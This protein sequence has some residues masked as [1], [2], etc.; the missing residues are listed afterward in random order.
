MLSDY[1]IY[2]KTVMKKL[3]RISS[4]K[5][6]F[7]LFFIFLFSCR[8]DLQSI[9]QPENYIDGNFSQVFDAFWNGM[10]NNY[11]FWDIDTTNWD[12][13]Y[14][15][16]KP[17]FE[18]LN[19]NDSNDVR[20]SVNYF[21]QMTQG[22]VDSHFN[23][24]FGYNAIQDSTVDPAYERKQRSSAFHPWNFY[25]PLDAARY[26]DKGYISG[27]DSTT[28]AGDLRFA[29]AGTIS[30]KILFFT[31]NEFELK[32]SYASSKANGLQPVLKYFFNYV[33]D[34]P[35]NIKGII[36]DLRGNGGGAVEDLN[37]LMGRMIDKPLHI[38]YTRYK[39]GNGR[40]DYTPW[41]DAVITPQSGAA[42]LTI[43]IIVLADNYSVSL[44]ELTTMAV[45][46]LPTGRFVGETTWGATGP[47]APNE[48]FNGGQ[49]TAANFLFAYTSSSMFKYIDGNIYE[50]KGF[51]PDVSVPYNAAALRAGVDLQLEKAISLIP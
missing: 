32:S 6:I 39:S 35:A 21:R 19:L 33:Q 1:S 2:T 50:G 10:N 7:S 45:H 4:G 20:K 49:F 9:N 41:A 42:A 11:I 48:F 34:P 44:A 17:V 22:L 16:Y 29:L 36:L 18:K 12:N 28:N 27:Y 47:L 5:I 3:F 37:F 15:R 38:G 24:S 43:P 8:K 51:P 25:A 26:L 46:S 30:Q 14:T 31:F 40:L 23:L 13:M